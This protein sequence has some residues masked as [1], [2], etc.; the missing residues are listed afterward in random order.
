M[1][2]ALRAALIAAAAATLLV[3]PADRWFGAVRRE[4]AITRVRA[5]MAP[6]ADALRGAV[7]RRVGLLS[8][9]RSFAES[10][11]TR[12]ALDAE[13]PLFARGTLSGT[14][15]VRAVQ[16]VEGGRIVTTW[17]LEGN[18]AAL[19]YD[20]LAD[21][22]PELGGDVRRA[23]ETGRITVTGPIALV[24]GGTGLLVRQRLTQRAGFPE[25]AAIILDVPT[26]VAEAGI[27]D[28][29][30]GL[31]LELLG[32]TGSWFAGDVAGSAIAP[33]TLSV[34]V[35]DGDWTLLGAPSAGWA[36]SERRWTRAFRGALL[37]AIGLAGLVGFAL[38]AREDRLVSEARDAES[39]LELAL[40]AGGMALWELDIATAVTRWSHGA[41]GILGSGPG[42]AGDDVARFFALVHPDDRDRVRQAVAQTRAGERDG[43]VEEHRLA[44]PDGTLRW[45]L[46]IAEL[47]R[48]DEGRPARIFGI[49]SDATERHRLQ[50]RLQ[51]AQRLEAVGRLAAGVAHDFNNLLTTISGHADLAS[52]RA[53]E[54][55]PAAAAAI[56]EDLQHVIA[57]AGRGARL[58]S[59][60]LAF[61]RRSSSAPT[62]LDLSRA[63]AEL[64]PVL[65]RLSG[66]SVMLQHELAT[67][68][69]AILVD[70]GQLTQVVLNLVVNARD[71]M[72][73]GGTVALRTF[74][75]ASGGQVRPD[76]APDGAWV[77]LEVEDHGVGMSR[78]VRQRIFEPYFTT[79][80]VGRG[81][82]LGLAV[83]YGAVESAGG[84]IIVQSTEGIGTVF[85]VYFPPAQERSA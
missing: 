76:N 46:T 83:A 31:R 14:D 15:G 19:N 6:Y 45:V 4:A 50:E 64:L 80:E 12:R 39:K 61:G 43:F 85:H 67:G 28:A 78:E 26:L 65:E 18:E 11:R 34:S 32:R 1:S 40:Q 57:T 5:G 20:L 59:Q 2:R 42:D 75:V 52:E 82:G 33:E 21:P 54:L 84:C 74:A 8:A 27:P 9:A 49:V 51:H 22:R 68:L 37:M 7:A 25:L 41:G 23:L 48:D 60:L 44:L 17:P 79:K 10:R 35:D 72:P 69:P 13:F 62:R 81:T 66:E 30:S 16:L 56:A 53:S 38:G 77:C 36:A 58:T 55:P 29:R 70:P 47:S 73:T 24:Q 63:V 3:I 71:A